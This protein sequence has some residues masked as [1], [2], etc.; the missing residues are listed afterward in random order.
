MGI[1]SRKNST[2]RDTAKAKE[3][4][5]IEIISRKASLKRPSVE[6]KTVSR[7]GSLKQNAEK[8]Q[9]PC[10]N[11]W[12]Q[13][14]PKIP[15]FRCS[16]C[17]VTTYLKMDSSQQSSTTS[18][19][20]NIVCNKFVL[21]KVING[22]EKEVKERKL[23]SRED[24]AKVYDSVTIYL[25]NCF[26]D[27]TIL[28]QSFCPENNL[29]TIDYLS[30]SEFYEIVM[31]LPTRRPFYRLL[32]VSNELLRR[33]NIAMTSFKWILIILNNPIVRQALTGRIPKK[34][35]SVKIRTIAYDLGKKCIGFL[36]N[37]P[38][39]ENSDK[40]IRYLKSLSVESTL[41]YIELLNIYLTFQL[42]RIVRHETKT[43]LEKYRPFYP[44]IGNGNTEAWIH[45]KYA[46]GTNNDKTVVLRDFR[47]KPFQYEDDW[48]IKTVTELMR[49]FYQVNVERCNQQGFSNSKKL[50][51]SEFYNTML[52]VID[53]RKDFDIWRGYTGND[54][55]SKFINQQSWNTSS[56]TFCKYPF[57][58]SL[59]LKISIMEY[60]FKRIMEYEAENAFLTSLDK[61]KMV[62]VYFKIRVRRNRITN[63]SLQCIQQHQG[64][65]LKSLRIEFI[66][67]PGIDAGGLRKEWFLL[68]TKSLFNPMNGL[69]VSVEE[70]NLSWI[71]IHDIQTLNK[72]STFKNELFFLFGV[73]VAL[74]IFNSTILDLQFPRTFYK[75]LCNEP[76]TFDDYRE[77]YPVTAQNL[78]KMLQYENDDF[79]EV[80]GLT[81]ET[82]YKDPLKYALDNEK[83]KG[84]GMVSVELCKNGSKM[85]VTQANKQKF[86]N[87]WVNFYLN[88][89]IINQISQFRSGFDR[90]FARTKSISLLNSEEL[91][92]LLCGDETQQS[93]DFKMLR[94]VTKY[95]GG[96]SDDSRVVA[97]FWEIVEGWN[98][99]LQRKLLSFITGSDRIPATGI[100]TLNFKI[101][102]L[103]SKDKN[104]LPLSHTCF[105]ELCLWE[106]SSRG[107]LEKKLLYAITESEGFGFR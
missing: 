21:E 4:A 78:M 68:L 23:T 99:K 14:P 25:T 79:E 19:K 84:D 69:F 34:F 46:L 11:S 48:H 73:V 42:H 1:F 50:N 53:Y 30:L 54:Q 95:S 74:A 72:S 61:G 105:N 26:Q 17:Q 63:D 39:K 52:D 35:E 13:V 96:F 107:K 16:I 71:A 3:N 75:K 102:R 49:K 88:E 22:C 2:K 37:M 10:C 8:R 58:L 24:F 87:L 92:R 6:G 31:N 40:L 51:V 47:F 66:D 43:A 90:V 93:Y 20:E 44:G 18:V 33:S 7:V 45:D 29:D 70:S 9:C 97:W 85:K 5:R 60:E 104:N 77:I 81:F 91:E 36:S 106:Y 80:F 94:S 76:L 103:G 41:Q 55:L 56:F 83:S 57:L 86:I 67:E 82:T 28:N 89:S 38:Y 62:N 32:C 64:D 27:A 98:Y 101:S 12:I 15:K 65:L 100:S 59:G